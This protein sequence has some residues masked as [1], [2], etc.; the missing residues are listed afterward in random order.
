ML[1]TSTRPDFEGDVIDRL[2][3]I[4]T[5][6]EGIKDAHSDHEAR[7]RGLEKKQWL[8]A[9]GASALG[10]LIAWLGGHFPFH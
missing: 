9:G 5:H 2:A 1:S 3:R 8:L 7:I 10:P 6:L 4:E